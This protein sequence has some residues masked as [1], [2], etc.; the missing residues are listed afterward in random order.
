MQ[1]ATM[2]VGMNDWVDSEGNVVMT[3]GYPLSDCTQ[4]EDGTWEASGDGRCRS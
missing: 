1:P 2:N 3:D 4:L